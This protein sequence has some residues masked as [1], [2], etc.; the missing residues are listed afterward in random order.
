M[1]VMYIKRVYGRAF[2]RSSSQSDGLNK[3]LKVNNCVRHDLSQNHVRL[4]RWVL[5]QTGV[6]FRPLLEL[7]V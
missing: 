2:S 1:Y 3:P 5:F 6:L 4:V 7:N